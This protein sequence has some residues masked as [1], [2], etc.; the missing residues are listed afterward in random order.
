AWTYFWT[1]VLD[2]RSWHYVISTRLADLLRQTGSAL[3]EEGLLDT[4]T[5]ILLLTVEDLV[6]IAKVDDVRSYRELYL[7]RKHE[8]E[9]HRRLTPPPFLGASPDLAPE[10]HMAAC[11]ARPDIAEKSTFQGNGFSP[12]RAIGL[13]RKIETLDDPA[14]LSSLTSE[15]ILVCPKARYWRPDWLSLFMVIKG[16]IT[17]RGVQLQHATQIARE[18]GIPFVN[19]PEEDWDAIPDNARLWI[20]GEAGLVTI[21]E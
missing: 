7:A 20:D 9:S 16:L 18:C 3:V 4:I 17:V 12:G 15:H 5:D 19:L 6:E 13:S 14:L 1:P 21:M 2:D 10:E 11:D 8:Y